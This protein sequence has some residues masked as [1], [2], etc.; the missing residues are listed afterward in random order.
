MGYSTCFTCIVP[1]RAE[2]VHA[3]TVQD[4]QI[5]QVLASDVP[6]M[7]EREASGRAFSCL[8]DGQVVACAGLSPIAD[9]VAGGW[10]LLALGARRHMVTLT[11][12][13]LAGIEAAPERTILIEVAVGFEAGARWAQMLGFVIAD[14]PPEKRGDGLDYQLWMLTKWHGS[15]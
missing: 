3:M 7:E 6:T 4:A 8:K 9:D 5:G 12:A 13:M 1:F 10:A 2:H 14:S 15:R 11:R